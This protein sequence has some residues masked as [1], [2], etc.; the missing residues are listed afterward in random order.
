MSTK[1]QRTLTFHW[2]L[3]H[4]TISTATAKCG[5]KICACQH[6]PK[7]HHGPYYRWTGRLDGKLTTKTLSKDV[8]KECE[9]RIRNYRKLQ[10]QLQRLLKLAADSAPWNKSEK[11]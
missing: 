11:D 4:G 9:R 2:P 7:A 3:L 10:E 6:D 5:Q 8:A 1:K